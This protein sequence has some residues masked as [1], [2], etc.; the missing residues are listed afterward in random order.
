MLY[1]PHQFQQPV[2]IP[3]SSDELRADDVMSA[4]QTDAVGAASDNTYIFHR[5]HLPR[6][7][8]YIAA[9]R[10][11]LLFCMFYFRRVMQPSYQS[12]LWQLFTITPGAPANAFS[13]L[14]PE[15]RSPR[16][17]AGGEKI[18]IWYAWL[19]HAFDHL[20]FLT[21]TLIFFRF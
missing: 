7:T 2:I 12:V 21:V 10:R 9:C 6:N 20:T 19:F 16:S 11:D 15:Y 3:L 14:G 4:C 5:R 1:P 13:I 8:V 18:C 17:V